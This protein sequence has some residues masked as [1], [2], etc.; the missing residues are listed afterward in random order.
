MKKFLLTFIISLSSFIIATAQNVGIG[1]SAPNASAALDISSTNKGFLLPRMTTAQRN[2]IVSPAVGL[3]I[4]NLDDGCNDTYDGQNWAKNCSSK[5]NGGRTLVAGSWTKKADIG[6]NGRVLAVGFSIGTK[7]YIG[8][9]D[10][11]NDYSRDFWEYDPLLNSWTQKADFGGVRRNSAVG[12]SIGAKGYIGTG[13]DLFLLKDFWEYD[14]ATNIWIQKADFGGTAR[15]NAVG[16]S[17]GSKGYI[18]AGDDISSGYTKDFWEFDPLLNSWTQKADF[19]GTARTNAVGFSIGAKGYIGTGLDAIAPYKKDFWEFTPAGGGLGTWL[20]KADFGGTARINAV[21]FSIGSFGYI[22]TGDNSLETN[23]FWKYSPAGNVWNKLLD[24]SGG[25]N[26]QA[27]GFSIGTNGYVGTGTIGFYY[28]RD[29]WEYNTENKLGKEYRENVPADANR[30]IGH[31]WT[32]DAN[33][34]YTSL[35]NVN[36]TVRG[37]LTVEGK[38]NT[39]IIQLAAFQT[40]WQNYG[41]GYAPAKYYKDKEGVVHLS[42]LVKN[43]LNPAPVSII[44]VLPVGFRPLDGQRIFIVGGVNVATRIEVATDGKVYYTFGGSTADI[45]LDGITFRAEL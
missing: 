42:G 6:V 39:G 44:F 29:F 3:Q 22:G 38:I 14:P 32:S 25:L 18:G 20:Q 37:N 13:Y 15:R 4:F 9:G 43:S 30:Y 28:K 19:A 36:A 40:N 16:F 12:F 41:N 27:V 7:G 26:T 10:D 5:D 11:G 1:T 34:L 21:G 23:D 24:F 8:T 45:S 17:I 35:P 2:T 31:D 33:E